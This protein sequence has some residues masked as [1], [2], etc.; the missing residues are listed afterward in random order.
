MDAARWARIQ[1][2]FHDAVA[3][4]VVERRP[5]LQDAVPGD[6]GLVAE[7]LSMLDEDGLR[8]SI[9]DRD[10]ALVAGDVLSTTRA[11]LPQD[12]FGPYRL[13]RL[14]GEGGMGVVYLAERDDLGSVAA[15]K[16]LRDAWLSPARRERF[17]SEQRLLAQLSH[18][19]IARLFDADTLADGTPW[20][21]M[22]YVEGVPL[23]DYCTA[24]GSA[25]AERL[26]FFR[27]V[28]E[29]VQHA[30]RHLVVHRDLKPSNI[31]LTA[32]GL[33]KLLDFGIS[34]Q[35]DAIDPA[36]DVTRTAL[37]LMTP[38]YAAPEQFRG[39]QTGMHTDVYAL[40]VVLYELLSGRLPFDLSN[41]A[42]PEAE[43]VIVGHEPEKP[44]SAA[45]LAGASRTA[46]ADLDVLCL[47]AMHKEPARRYRTVDALIRDI[48][49]YLAGEP[50]EARRDTL[51]YRASKFA[52]RNWRELSAAAAIVIT[53]VGLVTF[54]TWQLA[55]ARNTALAEAARTQR[56]QSFMLKLFEGDD[57]AAGP[58][59]NLRVITLVDRG[60][61][62]A[63]SLDREPGVQA[64]LYQT[65]GGIYRKLGSFDRA[66][67]LLTTALD[68]RRSLLGRDHPDVAESLVALG[69]LRTDQAKLEEA[70]NLIRSGLETSRRGRPVDGPAVARATAALGRVLQER[71]KYADAIAVLEDA[72][73]AY[74]SN[75][76]PAPDV[77][78]TMYELANTHFYA[79][80]YDESD[81][82]NARVLAMYRRLYG[83]RHPHVA[84]VLV[85]LG[86][87]QHERGRY[88]DAER[89]YRQAL[90]MTSSW[91]GKD[92]YQT[93]AK[94]TMLGR[95]LVRDDRPDEAT[96][97]LHQALEIRQRVFGKA[98]PQVASTLN[99]L[100]TIALG[101]GQL[102]EAE[103][104]F[105]RMADT[106]RAVYG[107]SNYLLGIA[108]SNLAS[109]HIARKQ[110]AQ[111][112]A[113]YREVIEHFTRTLSADHLNT[114]IA[115]IKLGRA[116]VRQERYAEAEPEILAG[117]DNLTKQTSSTVSW[118]KAAREDLVAVYD[119]LKQP[120]NARK[121][122][123]ELAA[124]ATK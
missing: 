7:V 14:I 122:R 105:V 57:E 91:Y 10:V 17:V 86:A 71:G 78:D 72:V 80:H 4:P 53:I 52:R 50:L 87:N 61:Q 84:D 6:D 31:L 22:E 40:G 34:K 90:D 37:R 2:L 15:I 88:K 24:R 115:R 54:Y 63:R 119:A 66:E 96:D 82:L 99:E 116:L 18:P 123:A 58:A 47:A 120:E 55:G 124:L 74:S 89:F 83:E 45:K 59:E 112:E 85:N 36:A 62:E 60:V 29:A 42:P 26:R 92:H 13:M 16:I 33:V 103:S 35:L 30:H 117:Y 1:S 110:Y 118:L 75:D 98:H 111:A 32:E 19:S 27:E 104:F 113:M 101:R 12:A 48:D 73:R 3:L 39:A 95:V 76:A 49:H 109:V 93:A 41:L 94:L 121:Y 8:G 20:F 81:A 21:A 79:G 108:R 106:Y 38:A 64:E 97:L 11:S 9:L 56:I 77:A 100:G 44:S 68:Q 28:C 51:G 67:S 70:E 23:T 46:W 65:L 69:M 5:F 102:D 114:G 43:A 25:I 107:D